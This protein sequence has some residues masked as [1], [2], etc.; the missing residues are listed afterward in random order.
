VGRV[1]CIAG[2]FSLG[3]LCTATAD[4]VRKHCKKLIESMGSDGGFI[5]STGAGMQ[6]AKA[7][8]VKVIIVTAKEY[9]VY[10]T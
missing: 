4:D 2:N 8:N 10:N 3:L 5:F 7:E 1:S 6:G 9:G